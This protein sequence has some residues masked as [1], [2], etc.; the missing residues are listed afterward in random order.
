[1]VCAST[2][3]GVVLDSVLLV[4]GYMFEM[5]L[6]E[7]KKQEMLKGLIIRGLKEKS[8]PLEMN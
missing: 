4:W 3:Y 2:S 5:M 1:L 7:K 6:K 8:R